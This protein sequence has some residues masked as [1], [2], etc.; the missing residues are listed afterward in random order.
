NRTQ[1]SAFLLFAWEIMQKSVNECKEDWAKSLRNYYKSPQGSLFEDELQGSDAA[2]SSKLSLIATDQGVRGFLHIIN[3]MI[4]I[5]S[6]TLDLN[7]INSSDE[8]KEDR[9]DHEDVKK[10]LTMFRKSS[11]LKDYIENITKELIK[12]DWRTASTEGLT[13]VERQKQ[14][15]YKGSSGYKEIRMELLKVLMNS[16]NKIIAQNAELIFKELGYAN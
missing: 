16:K 4:Y 3:D 2:F 12:F 5:H 14:M 13:T 15:I 11:K 6:D 8:V 7:E 9:I 1:Q 10:A